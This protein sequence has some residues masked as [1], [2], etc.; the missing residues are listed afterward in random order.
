MDIDEKVIFTTTFRVGDLTDLVSK[1]YG[2]NSR[3]VTDQQI[4]DL[5]DQISDAIMN[6]I[7]SFIDDNFS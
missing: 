2:K 5:Q 6:V 1:W 7:Q 4:E 3:K